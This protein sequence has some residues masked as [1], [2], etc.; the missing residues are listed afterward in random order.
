MPRILITGA[1]GLVGRQLCADLANRGYTVRAAIRRSSPVPVGAAESVAVDDIGPHTSWR[2]ALRDVDHVIHAAARVH[3]MSDDP[4]KNDLYFATNV[5]GTRALANAAMQA[6]VRRF[7]FL[8]SVKVNGEET[9]DRAYTAHD[10]PRPQD[11]Y[12]LSK[13]QAEQLLLATCARGNMTCAIVRS[14]LVYGP[15]VRANFLRLMSWVDKGYPLPLRAIENRRSLVS[16]WNLSQLLELLITTPVVASRIWMVSDGEDLSTSE[17]IRRL[18]SAMGKPARLF[19]VPQSILR[20][21]ARLIGR[22]EEIS[23]L[24]G[25]LRVDSTETRSALG[26]EPLISMDAGLRRTVEWYEANR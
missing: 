20:F 9:G 5:E 12:A 18:A 16:I 26:W 15:G 7:V 17:L 8:S 25:S 1:S 21:G 14:P 3:V 6:R 4:A 22:S 10:A 2:E 23:R 24:C 11:A 13:W 19:R